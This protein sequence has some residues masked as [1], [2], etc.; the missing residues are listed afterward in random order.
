MDLLFDVDGVLVPAFLFRQRLQEEYGVPP[1]KTRPFFEGDFRRCARGEADL[2]DELPKLL[3]LADWTGTGQEF[4]DLWFSTENAPLAP[5]LDFVEALRASGI[6]CHVAS[7]QER[8]RARYLAEEMGF[9]DHFDR[10]FFS[11][12][13]G[14]Q[15]PDPDYFHQIQDQ[16]GR[17]P[18]ELLLVDDDARNV[19]AARRAGWGAVHFTEV[20]DLDAVRSELGRSPF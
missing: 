17:L 4:V 16:L 3:Q 9:K 6:R 7:N 19:A 18:S 20:G 10:L 8:H 11:H 12:E 5:V 1:I 13:L 15:K 2:L 14:V